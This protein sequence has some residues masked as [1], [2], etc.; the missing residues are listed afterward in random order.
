MY[1]LEVHLAVE[2][3][4]DW[5]GDMLLVTKRV[6]HRREPWPPTQHRIMTGTIDELD[7]LFH[8]GLQGLYSI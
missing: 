1:E 6:E 8:E 4:P 5:G 3:H 2:P 7:R